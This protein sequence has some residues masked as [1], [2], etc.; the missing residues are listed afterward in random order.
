MVC[1]SVTI[2]ISHAVA[3]KSMGKNTDTR[4]Q[5]QENTQLMGCV[6]FCDLCVVCLN[7]H[8]MG[9]GNQCEI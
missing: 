1:S 3:E 9:K 6:I 4:A 5:S 7:E 2:A 8:M